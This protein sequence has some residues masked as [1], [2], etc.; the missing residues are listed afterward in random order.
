MRNFSRFVLPTLA[1]LMAVAF[2]FTFT[3]A[4]AADPCAPYGIPLFSAEADALRLFEEGAGF[5]EQN[6]VTDEDG[7]HWY[8]HRFEEEGI[9][10]FN[11]LIIRGGRLV[12]LTSVSSTE[13]KV[14]AQALMSLF[15]DAMENEQEGCGSQVKTY[16][17]AGKFR[18]LAL[19]PGKAAAMLTLE[20]TGG[21]VY[22]TFVYGPAAVLERE[23]SKLDI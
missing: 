12:V 22:L 16:S 8:N 3:S 23:A 4:R 13:E 1:V 21:R 19:R 5:S 18:Y 7:D 11:L 14:S 15:K 20:A 6:R 2:L 9:E 10:M 17:S